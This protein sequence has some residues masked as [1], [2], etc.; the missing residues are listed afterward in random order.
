M[1]SSDALLIASV[2]IAGLALI[3][4]A[5]PWRRMIRQGPGLPIWAFL[6]RQRI[7]RGDAADS[8]GAQAVKHAELACAICSS[9][10]IC[11]V[12]LAASPDAVPPENCPNA[13]LLDGFGI[14][15]EKARR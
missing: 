7:T 10:E 11:R 15:V 14:G 13:P 3:A 8:V 9:R 12:R 6:R 4:A 2:A 5:L 1:D